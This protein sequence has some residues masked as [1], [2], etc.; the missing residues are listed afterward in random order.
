VAFDP[1]A[2]LVGLVLL[3][4]CAVSS[5]HYGSKHATEAAQLREARVVA[6][7]LEQRQKEN[8]ATLGR[9]RQLRERDFKEYEKYTEARHEAEQETDRI[10]AGL[11]S[12]VIRLRV[13]IKPRSPAA[14]AHPGGPVATGIEPEGQAELTAD[15][16]AFLVNLLARGDEGIRK[17]AEVVD[18]YE[19]LRLACA[20][21]DGTAP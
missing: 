3:I 15:A 6:A 16:G 13:P 2:W 21:G 12:D 7:A 20:A 1:R 9:E 4:I 8:D 14:E 11:R 5:Y 17:H 19:R 18:R 10:I